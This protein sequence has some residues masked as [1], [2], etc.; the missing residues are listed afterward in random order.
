M[1][2]VPESQGAQIFLAMN[3]Y[4]MGELTRYRPVSLTTARNDSL[5]ILHS[6]DFPYIQLARVSWQQRVSHA[7]LIVAGKW[8]AEVEKTLPSPI[9]TRCAGFIESSVVQQVQ[10]D[11]GQDGV[12]DG[13]HYG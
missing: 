7:P 8:S 9:D 13:E 3:L 1:R 4:H 11:E 12:Q 2:D 10:G 5:K 6:T